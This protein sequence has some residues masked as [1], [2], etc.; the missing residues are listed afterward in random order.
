[1]RTTLQTEGTEYLEALK[2]ED[3]A[4]SRNRN[5]TNVTRSWWARRGKWKEAGDQPGNCGQDLGH[6]S[7]NNR[8]PGNRFKQGCGMVRAASLEEHPGCNDEKEWREPRWV[9]GDHARGY[10]AAQVRGNDGGF[11][12][13]EGK[14][15]FG[16]L[17]R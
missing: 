2:G 10:P 7:K 11:D 16:R 9:C 6:A 8:K 13:E 12:Q 3:L 4:E 17:Y 14:V 1:M 15:G 5:K